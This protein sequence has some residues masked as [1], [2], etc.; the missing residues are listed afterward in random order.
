MLLV[1]IRMEGS[2]PP[3]EERWAHELSNEQF[4]GEDDLDHADR[5]ASVRTKIQRARHK[6]GSLTT[7][8]A[9]A[10]YTFQDQIQAQL[11]RLLR[12]LV[13]QVWLPRDLSVLL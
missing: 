7:M 9:D 3:V 2:L 4:S 10:S 13:D 11:P 8:P 1:P 6:L 5:V 12:L